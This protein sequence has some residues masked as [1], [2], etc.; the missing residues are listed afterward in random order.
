[1]NI[2]LSTPKTI[3]IRTKEEK[4]IRPSTESKDSIATGLNNDSNRG[5]NTKFVFPQAKI[6]K[7]SWW[8]LQYQCE[9]DG[10][11]IKRSLQFVC[12]K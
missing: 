2:I 8:T 7:E 10:Q 6:E 5:E 12:I 4:L 11:N 3:S 9:R 1:M